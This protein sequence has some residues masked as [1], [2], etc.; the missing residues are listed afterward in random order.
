MST[1]PVATS[2]ERVVAA[3]PT[4]FDEDLTLDRQAFIDLLLELEPE[5]DSVL[6]AGTTGEFLALEDD[7]RLALVADALA[8][9]GPTRT[10]A[11]VGAASSR[12]VHR[13]LDATAAVG[14][15]RLALLTPYYVP[16]D[17]AALL[18]WYVSAAQQLDGR[19]LYA[20]LF[21]E[22]TGVTV[23][24][25]TIAEILGLEGVGGLKA[26]GAAAQ[27]L[28]DW[29]ALSRP[30]Q[31]VWSGDDGD[32]AGVLGHG[33][34]GI[35]SG[36]AAAFPQMFGRLRR[37]VIADEAIPPELGARVDEAVAA[38]GA[39]LDLLH[40]ALARRTGSAWTSRLP[41]SIA[42]PTQLERLGAL[43]S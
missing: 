17:Q 22:R 23:Q 16:L 25:V 3:I 7:E 37:S 11:H 13:L 38:A 5:V 40:T 31:S 43:I 8:V 20:Y 18:A 9:F 4:P 21:P 1:G 10:I 42:T 26:S 2:R 34:T 28:D 32:L 12:Q 29:V 33:A 35:V 39:S 27:R 14:V 15:Q 24:P 19:V 36:T 41:G 6:V 30:G